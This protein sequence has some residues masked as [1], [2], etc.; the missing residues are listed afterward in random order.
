MCGCAQELRQAHDKFTSEKEVAYIDSFP[1]VKDL[2]TLKDSDVQTILKQAER[3]RFTIDDVSLNCFP[4]EH[5]V[6]RLC[7][8]M[9]EHEAR[10]KLRGYELV[11]SLNNAMMCVIV[12]QVI[13]LAV[14]G[15]PTMLH[16]P[17]TT[18]FLQKGDTICFVARGAP[19]PTLHIQHYVIRTL[20]I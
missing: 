3:S 1:E 11:V 16:D 18:F 7:R 19:C 14:E 2:F 9:A 5:R 20:G 13:I 10:V 12:V 15:P 17:V 4:P 8:V 6:R